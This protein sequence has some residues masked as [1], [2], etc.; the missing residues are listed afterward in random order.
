[1]PLPSG[2]SRTLKRRAAVIALALTVPSAPAVAENL[3]GGIVLTIQRHASFVLEWRGVTIYVDPS[4]G[5]GG[6][7]FAGT[8][9]PDLILVTRG[10]LDHLDVDKIR[11]SITPDTL[12]LA[13]DRLIDLRIRDTLGFE[14]GC[15]FPAIAKLFRCP[16]DGWE[17][18]GVLPGDMAAFRGVRIDVLSGGHRDERPDCCV[19]YLLTLGTTRIFIAG[20]AEPTAEMLALRNIDIAFLP[21]RPRGTG[22]ETV[23][24]VVAAMRPRI[25]YPYLYLRGDDPARFAALVG[26]MAE[27]RLRDWYEGAWLRPRGF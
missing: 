21:I 2:L 3:G 14:L 23:A 6:D 1:M 19:S 20:D 12:I 25:V 17:R 26:R 13:P 10:R 24:A 4:R 15:R 11:T 27:V 16:P 8:P 9:A 5:P 18:R 7:P 22:A